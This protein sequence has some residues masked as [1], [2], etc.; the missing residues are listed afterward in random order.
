MACARLASLIYRLVSAAGSDGLTEPELA[1]KLT[2]LADAKAQRAIELLRPI[3]AQ[4]ETR[5]GII[6]L[7]CRVT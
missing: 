7:I 4:R 2:A 6:T 5:F 3:L 1:E